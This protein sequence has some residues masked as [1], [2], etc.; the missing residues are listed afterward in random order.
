M[1]KVLRVSWKNNDVFHCI[2]L[3]PPG[4]MRK[5]MK[6]KIKTLRKTKLSFLNIADLMK[7]QPEKDKISL[8]VL[9]SFAST[10]EHALGRVSFCIKLQIETLHLFK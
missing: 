7:S 5:T 10:Q 3:F 8:D 4:K 6:V 1:T 9:K 2:S